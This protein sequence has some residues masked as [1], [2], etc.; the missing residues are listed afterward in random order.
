MVDNSDGQLKGFHLFEQT[1]KRLKYVPKK[2]DRMIYIAGVPMGYLIAAVPWLNANT[3]SGFGLP[4]NLVPEYSDVQKERMESRRAIKEQRVSE[5]T[6][7][8][9]GIINN[10]ITK[11]PA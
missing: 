6:F 1:R 10:R 3:W 8:K 4:L 2:E 11:K 9:T 7:K 5:R